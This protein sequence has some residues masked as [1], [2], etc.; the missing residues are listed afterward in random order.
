MLDV[1]RIRAEPD[2]VRAGLA[3]RADPSLAALVDRAVE[4]DGRQR[5]LTRRRDEIRARIKDLSRASARPGA[6]AT[7]PRPRRRRAR[8]ATS[9]TDE[10]ALDAE[11]DELAAELRDAPAA[12]PQPARAPTRPT[13]PAPTTTS[14]SAPHGYDARV[15]RRAPAGPALGHRRRARHPRPRAG[16]QD[17]RLDV[18]DVP[19]RRRPPPAGARAAQPRPQRRRL[20]GDPAAH[21]RAHR[22]DGLDRPPAEVRRRR[23]PRRARRPLGHP[24]RRGP[25]HVA[26]PRR[27]PRRGRPARCGTAPTRAASAARPARP[28]ATPAACCASTSSTRSSCSPWPRPPSR[29]SPARRTCSPAASRCSP[30]SASPTGCST[31]APATSAN[32][33]ARTWDLEAYAPGCDQWLEVSSVSWFSRLPGPPGQHP[34]AA[35]RRPQGHRGL[36]HGQRLGP[37]L[38][39]DGRRLPR[40]PPPPDGSIA[41]VEALRPY[42]GGADG[43]DGAEPPSRNRSPSG[44]S[45]GELEPDDLADG[46]LARRPTGRRTARR[47]AGPDHGCSSAV[48]GPA[49]GAA[50]RCRT[51]STRTVPSV[52]AMRS[53]IGGAPCSMAFVTISLVHSTTRSSGSSSTASTTAGR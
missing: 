9:A 39:P 18:H 17:Q 22:H 15:L 14:C 48:A 30:T 44:A 33:A 25:A 50:A 28:A 49:A 36:P 29:R 31:S 12:H 10:K 3:R 5:S 40:D 38:A 16:R 32:S 23:L 34:V 21:P 20:R 7:R 1:R 26:A 24:H 46:E 42:L 52:C 8:A 27:D 53:S 19:R 47:S 6:T 4:L 2:A 13:V 11:H 45:D 35:R 37:G 43:T 41:V 51:T